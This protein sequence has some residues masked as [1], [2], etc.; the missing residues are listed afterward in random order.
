[1]PLTLLRSLVR[2]HPGVHRLARAA[3]ARLTPSAEA[4]LRP[5]LVQLTRALERPVFVKVGANDGVTG[6]PCG[7]WFLD[8]PSWTGLLIEPVPYCVDT[9]R[10][11]YRDRRDRDDRRD[12][13]DRRDRFIIEQAAVGAAPGTATFYYV[14]EE[15]KRALP[16][17]PSW[18][19]QLGSFDRQHIVKHLDGRLAPFIRTIEVRVAP[20]DELVRRHRLTRIDLLHIDT[21]GHDLRVLESLD[22]VAFA[23][24]VVLVEHKHL[25]PRDRRA[26]KRRLRRAR[27]R[28]RRVGGDLLAVHRQAAAL[29]RERRSQA[30]R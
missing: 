9:L 12:R 20:L 8:H 3:R 7:R 21:E 1:M 29:L 5:H 16:D 13:R 22:L 25:S 2:A 26:L 18:Y 15:A 17:L 4:A 30:P 27:Y 6:D 10:A 24:V 23:P 14:A 11:V 28:V 19:D